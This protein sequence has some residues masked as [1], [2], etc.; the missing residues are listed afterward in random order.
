MM[1]PKIIGLY[2][3]EKKNIVGELRLSP[4]NLFIMLL[5]NI[6]KEIF[7]NWVTTEEFNSLLKQLIGSNGIE[8]NLLNSYNTRTNLNLLR[9]KIW[10]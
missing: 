10:N 5:P 8:V 6:I 2:K 7:L 1:L 9:P 4:E 3:K